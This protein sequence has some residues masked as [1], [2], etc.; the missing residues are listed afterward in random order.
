MATGRDDAGTMN[1]EKY[2]VV[3]DT[4]SYRNLIRYTSFEDI[5]ASIAQLKEKEARK[6]IMAKATP[7]VAS[8]M[9]ANLAGPGKSPHYDDCLK[10]LIAMANHCCEEAENTMHIIPLPY[11]HLAINFFEVSPPYA[12][13]ITKNMAGVIGDFKIDYLK[14]VEGHLLKETFTKLKDYIDGE[15]PRWIR[16]VES[17]IEL[18]RHEALKS[19]P[20]IN[21]KDLRDKMLEF[22]DS[23]LFVPRI[24]M[25]IIFSL[26]KSLQIKMSGIEPATKGWI[27]PQMF[28]LSVA[29]YQWICRKI[30]MDNIDLRNKKSRETRWNW[31]WDYEVS[32]LMNDHL[33]NGRIVLL[34]TSDKD[35]TKMLKKYG[36]GGRV[37]DLNKYIEFLDI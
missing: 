8:E 25:A 7:V 29:F 1:S 14:A 34:V 32:F 23:G 10:G 15:E 18:A 30:V 37:M 24:S 2:A 4:N 36:Y 12:E 26:A 11:L 22:I 17:F 9:L 3:F 31:R 21:G 28:P 33:L 5:E 27:L 19:N 16:E 13:L 20:S 35:M 6:N